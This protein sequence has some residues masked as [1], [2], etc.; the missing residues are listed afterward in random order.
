MTLIDLTELIYRWYQ[1]GKVMANNQQLLKADF[2]QKIK[3]LFADLIRQRY[4]ES[5]K[6]D[7]YNRPDYSFVSP[8]LNVKR[9]VLGDPDIKGKRRVDMSEW[10]LYRLP[11]NAHFENVYPIAEGCGNQEVGEITQVD[12]GEE[13]FYIGQPDLAHFK[14]FVV[15][16][17]GLDTYNLPPCVKSLEV[18]STYDAGDETEI[19]MSMASV[20]TDQLLNVSL[21]IKKQYYSEQV[22]QRIMDENII[23]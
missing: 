15:K 23:K 20:I 16:G 4:Y 12:P 2:S 9:F 17:R 13:V 3:V 19:D 14:F 10:D 18:E 11:R 22:Q 7:E 5:R 1:S 6:A 8:L 21:G